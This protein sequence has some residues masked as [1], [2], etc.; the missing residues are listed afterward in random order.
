MTSL[1]LFSVY[2]NTLTGSIMS[3]FGNMETLDTLDVGDNSLTS[4]IPSQ[5]GQLQNLTNLYLSVNDLTGTIPSTLDQLINVENFELNDNKLT[6]SLPVSIVSNRIYVNFDVTGNLLSDL[7][8]VDGQA[9]CSITND[10]TGVE[11][12][13]YCNC[14]T[15][16]LVKEVE[17]PS[18]NKFG[19]KCQCEEALDC[20]DT[21]FVENNI[22][23]CVFCEA[24]GGFSNPDFLVPEWDYASC[25]IGADF[26]YTVSED[27]GTEEQ[28]NEARIEGYKQGCICPDYIPPDVSEVDANERV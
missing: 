26:V 7:P 4:T 18:T 28:C 22:T 15:D 10:F 14:A 27:F 3:E 24:E 25:N 20:C 1:V 6:G 21:Y 11:D 8:P 13:Q 5:L 2:T 16:C 12:E 23:N 19:K 17:Y 9:I